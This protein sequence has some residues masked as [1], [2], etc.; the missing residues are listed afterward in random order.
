MKKIVINLKHRQD[1]L[2]HF[3]SVNQKLGDIELIEAVNGWHID[4]DQMQKNG[5]AVNHK[6]R[7]PFK[8]RR[9][10]K[11]EVGCFISHYKAWQQVLA[12]NE[13]VLI[14]EDDAIIDFYKYKS[15]KRLEHIVE[16]HK[17]DLLYLGYNENIPENK[18]TEHKDCHLVRY[19]YN[20]HAYILTPEGANELLNSGFHR[21]IIPVDEVFSAMTDRLKM[22]ALKDQC[23]SQ[24][25]RDSL[26]TDIEP[27]SDLCWF[28]DFNAHAITI[29]SDT[30]KCLKLNESSRQHGFTVTNIG[31]NKE[32]LGGT[33]E[34]QG[35]GH[36]I[37]MLQE[38][39]GTLPDND[40]VLFTD[41]YDVFFV[42]DLDNIVR[43]YM[44]FSVEILFSA[45]K[46]CW[47]DESMA[48]KHPPAETDYKFLNSGGFIGRVG[49][50]KDLF[51]EELLASDD[52]Q[53][54]IQRIWT[55]DTS[56]WSMA[57]DY[58]QY[59]FQTNESNLTIRNKQLWNDFT[60]CYPAIYHGNGGIAA[61]ATLDNYYNTLY[62]STP[63]TGLYIPHKGKVE[64][65]EKDMLLV[66][67]MSPSQCERLI[68]LSDNHGGWAPLEGDKFPA[69]EIRMKEM[70]LWTELQQHWEETLYP[71]IEKHWWPM[72]M[73]GLRDAFVMRYSVDTQKTLPMHND[74]SLVTG[75]VK[76][77]E[78][79]KG[80]SLNFPRQGITND[81]VPVGK[82]IL[83]P[84]MVTHG[85]ECTE[86]LE[87]VKYS[88][89]MWSSRYPGDEN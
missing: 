2:E 72:Q 66:D 33:M 37:K 79:Y 86:L 76:L 49:A 85:H 53:L 1:R 83:F 46:A 64:I 16:D 4:H 70:G 56:R 10:T 41:A 23:A 73:Y 89:T 32:W 45:E 81:D 61:K 47:P 67:F 75:S 20:T 48:E 87:G 80:A 35:G 3:M 34:G 58:E 59:I 28:Q 15:G 29:G 39:L 69:Y 13:P 60:G 8:N 5:F 38:Y 40:V 26:G 52:D 74:A 21:K 77:N 78:A 42:T 11:G 71:I 9:I 27:E 88:L 7:D 55:Y 44:D 63:T 17:P 31:A 57:L 30:T 62:G 82:M 19:P 18:D 25:P 22:W 68:E 50:L 36:K 14:L 65:L 12:F 84:G 24:A 51:S 6:W 43:R 54:Y